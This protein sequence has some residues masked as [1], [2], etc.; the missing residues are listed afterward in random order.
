MGASHRE[1]DR[2]ISF[3]LSDVH[4]V[5][6]PV[7]STVLDS[8]VIKGKTLKLSRL[9]LSIETTLALLDTVV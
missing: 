9:L 3:V 1:W 8:N 4:N 2:V 6:M 7:I 5:E